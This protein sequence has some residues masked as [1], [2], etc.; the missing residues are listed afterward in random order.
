[1]RTLINHLDELFEA[2][3][4]FQRP[5]AK[6]LRPGLSDPAIQNLVEDLP[7]ALLED[8]KQLHK[9]RDGTAGIG[10]LKIDEL[11]LFP[12]FYF[13][14]LELALV[15]F[16]RWEEMLEANPA[17]CPWTINWFPIFMDVGGCYYAIDCDP[18]S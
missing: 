9:W 8:V 2:L 13:P 12:N 6:L 11:C 16:R 14:S 7:I 4:S 15:E 10:E 18:N 1:M 3:R 17:E 5:V